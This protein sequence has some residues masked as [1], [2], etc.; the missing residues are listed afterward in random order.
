[1]YT[2]VYTW[3]NGTLPTC[4]LKLRATFWWANFVDP[5]TS[6]PGKEPCHVAEDVLGEVEGRGLWLIE[7]AEA[8]KPTNRCGDGT[9]HLCSHGMLM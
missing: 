3:Y 6:P 4:V 1:M 8:S 7:A 9:C 5:A 2:H